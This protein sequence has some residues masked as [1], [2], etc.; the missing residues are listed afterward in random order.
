[1][2]PEKLWL[3]ETR[4]FSQYGLFIFFQCQGIAVPNDAKIKHFFGI[5]HMPQS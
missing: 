4:I 5:F 2:V 1:M 3:L